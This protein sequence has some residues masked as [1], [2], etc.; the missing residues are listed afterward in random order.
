MKR[1]LKKSVLLLFFLIVSN[2]YPLNG[3]EIN[4][5][6]K[7][8]EVTIKKKKWMGVWDYSVQDVPSEYSTGVLHITKKKK[9][10]KVELELPH[11]NLPA[12]RVKVNK[13]KLTFSVDIEGSPVDVALVMDRDSFTGESYTPDGT[14]MLEGKRRI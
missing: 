12:S 2:G 13:N 11:G 3:S 1:I 6:V 7:T 10:Y 8:L 5:D 4:N 9:E 14:F